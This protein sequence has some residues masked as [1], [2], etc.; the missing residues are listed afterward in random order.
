MNFSKKYMDDT[1]WAIVH[2]IRESY[3]SI[4]SVKKIRDFYRIDSLNYSKINFYWRSL[5]ELEEKRILK[6][7][8][9]KIPKQYRVLNYYKFFNIL[10]YEY[11]IN[12][13]EAEALV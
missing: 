2:F 7:I 8:N 9:S 1:V 13:Q 4:I 10:Q 3:N 12:V 11:V 5:Q 6:R